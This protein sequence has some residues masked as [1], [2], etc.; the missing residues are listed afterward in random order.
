MRTLHYRAECQR[1]PRPEG[2]RP[3]PERVTERDRDEGTD[4][5]NKKKRVAFWLNHR[6]ARPRTLLG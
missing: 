3:R 1:P 4:E 5:Q 2:R 6:L